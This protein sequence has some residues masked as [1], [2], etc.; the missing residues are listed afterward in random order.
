VVPRDEH[1]PIVLRSDSHVLQILNKGR[2]ISALV[3]YPCVCDPELWFSHSRSYTL[4][5]NSA[6]AEPFDPPQV[7]LTLDGNTLDTYKI[8]CSASGVTYTIP[9]AFDQFLAAISLTGAHEVTAKA[10][11]DRVVEL[12][13]DELQI[14]DTIPTGSIIRGTALRRHADL[15]LIVVLHYSKHVK[16]KTPKQLLEDVREVLAGSSKIVKKNGQA[17]T[18]YFT[19]W[20]NVDVVPASVTYNDNQTVKHYSVPDMVRNRWLITRPRAHNSSVAKA[21]E[22]KRSLIRMIKA[23]NHAHSELMSSYHIEV[24]VLS[25]PDVDAAKWPFEIYYFFDKASETIDQPLYHPNGTPGQVDDYLDYSTRR[26]LKERLV[27]ARNRADFARLT[28]SAAEAFRLYRVIFGDDFP[29]Y[30]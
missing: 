28:T 23:W 26:A 9:V 5:R 12:L 8:P 4:R 6:Q 14:L 3:V 21:S 15:D 17:V 20:P 30:G 7:H 24:L 29:A 1:N 2:E 25:M 13:K 27:D 18:L 22:S 11:R 19:K 10:R 16:G